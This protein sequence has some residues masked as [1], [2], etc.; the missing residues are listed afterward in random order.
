MDK[1][2][3]PIYQYKAKLTMPRP[4]SYRE[5]KE[6]VEEIVDAGERLPMK[7]C[8]MKWFS[9][10]LFTLFDEGSFDYSEDRIRLWS[11]VASA[12]E[13][14]WDFSTRWFAQSGDSRHH[15]K[16]IRF[17]V[18]NF[19]GKN[20]FF[21]TWSIVPV[22]LNAFMCANSRIL[23][24]LY[25][26]KG[27]RRMRNVWIEKTLGDFENVK[28]YNER[29]QWAK[30]QM[31]EIHWNET[32]GIW[33]DYDIE[34]KVRGRR[35]GKEEGIQTHSNTYYVSNAIPLYAKCYDDIDNETPHRVHEYLLASGRTFLQMKSLS[36][37]RRRH[38]FHKRT[39]HFTCNGKWTT[40][41]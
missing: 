24:S 39:S 5:D 17:S 38:E 1:N 13:T 12:A 31:R 41:G 3:F 29:Y 9:N 10:T 40:M 33:Y 34:K 15:M 6:L 37:E 26:I 27:G 25:E 7:H 36:T 20:L 8:S 19:L 16:S 2:R 14:G 30:R 11:E 21:R 4:E 18:N 32:D 23:A 22:D 35:E 28:K